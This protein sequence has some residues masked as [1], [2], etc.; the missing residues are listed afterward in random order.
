MTPVTLAKPPADN[1]EM[2]ESEI[3]DETAN[4]IAPATKNEEAIVSRM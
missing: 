4:R 2:S 1:R 3:V